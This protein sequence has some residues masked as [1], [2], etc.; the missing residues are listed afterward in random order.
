[1]TAYEMQWVV[2]M[3]T[4]P[5][6]CLFLRNLHLLMPQFYWLGSDN[7]LLGTR[8]AFLKL[9]VTTALFGTCLPSVQCASE[10]QTSAS[11]M[12]VYYN[13]HR[14]PWSLKG[15]ARI[16]HFLS[17]SRQLFVGRKAVT[18]TTFGYSNCVEVS[19]RSAGFRAGNIFPFLFAKCEPYAKL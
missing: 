18:C 14:T 1:M 11:F 19:L 7:N 5:A 6:S 8:P 17:S 13:V 10:I 12:Q 3:I 15:R 9:S 2:I 16:L 4:L